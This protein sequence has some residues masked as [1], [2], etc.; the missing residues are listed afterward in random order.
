VKVI[1]NKQCRFPSPS[2]IDDESYFLKATKN[3]SG[4]FQL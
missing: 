4:V 2:Y 1:S 3:I